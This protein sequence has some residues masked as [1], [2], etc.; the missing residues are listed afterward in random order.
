VTSEEPTSAGPDPADS[1]PPDPQDRPGPGVS[2]AESARAK[3][4]RIK[5][6]RAA[7]EPAQASPVARERE[8]TL[9]AQAADGIPS[10]SRPR[11]TKAP[12]VDAPAA[13]E[14]GP[15]REVLQRFLAPSKAPARIGTFIYLVALLNIASAVWRPWRNTIDILADYIPGAA[16]SFATVASIM[17]GLFLLLLGRSIKRGQSRAWWFAVILLSF[18]L[19]SHLLADPRLTPVA[20]LVVVV[21]LGFLIAYR[22]EF[23]SQ[24]D[25]RTRWGAPKVFALLLLGSLVVGLLLVWFNRHSVIG[26]HWP[27]VGNVLLY[28]VS[29]LLWQNPDATYDGQITQRAELV[30]TVL[31]VLG[32]VTVLTPLAMF[33]SPS[34]QVGTLTAADDARIRDSLERFPESLGYFNTRADKQVIWSDT[35]KAG[36]AYRVVGGVML[37]SGDPLGD[38]EAWP[39]AIKAFLDRA[40]R[41]AWTPA[42]LACS[43]LAGTIWIR[44]TGFQALEIGDEAIIDTAAFTLAGRSMRNVRQMVNRIRRQGYTTQMVRVREVPPAERT[45]ARADADAWRAGGTERGFS[46][47]TSRVLDAE[48]DPEAVVVFARRE[49]AVEG[50]LQFAPWGT[51][52]MSLDLMRR[53]P[54]SDPGVNELLI[55]DALAAAPHLGIRRVS[56]NFAMF[57]ST[58]ER[59]AR[60]GAGPVLKTWR[61]ILVVGNRWFQLE[62]LY[63]FNA[64]FAPTW[65]PRFVIYPRVA[66]FVRVSVAAGRAEAFIVGPSVRSLWNRRRRRSGGSS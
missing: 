36:I 37:A 6:E 57:R 48:R 24:S 58:F 15:S 66:D 45:Q 47:A 2:P 12:D 62:S 14:A 35:G 49:G 13:R 33:F 21:G 27:G 10:L 64:K 4:K 55:C 23:T 34:K 25:P 51:D 1:D 59:G 29:G 22:R 5:A 42:V 61:K 54:H 31:G 46:M 9:A 60:L 65:Y 18:S 3:R 26:Y 56:L 17:A 40:D 43:E 41:Y 28:V 7:A 38:A 16:Y 30:N 44:E 8:A 11:P 20:T 52:G 39:G 63:K 32:I 50:M 19:L 53:N